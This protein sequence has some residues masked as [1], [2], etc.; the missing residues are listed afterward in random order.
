[1]NN[2]M[3]RLEK[4]AQESDNQKF[5]SKK[6]GIIIF[7]PCLIPVILAFFH[8]SVGS[9]PGPYIVMGSVLAL[10]CGTLGQMR[11]KIIQQNQAIQLLQEKLEEIDSVP[12]RDS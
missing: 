6:Q 12:D 8:M 2:Y 11:A 1:M 5:A 9:N 4:K 3:S 7:L 10:V